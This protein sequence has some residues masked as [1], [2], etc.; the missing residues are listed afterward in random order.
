[1]H[2][3][4]IELEGEDVV[5]RTPSGEWELTLRLLQITGH[6]LDWVEL[7]RLARPFAEKIAAATRETVNI[8]ALAGTQAVCVD[9]VRGNER[10]QLDFNIGS[11]GPL[12]CGGAGKAILAYLPQAK[13]ELAMSPPLAQFMP[14]TLTRP[15]RTRTRA[16][17][18]PWIL[19][20]RSGSCNGNLL[21]R[22]SRARP[23]RSPGGGH[24]HH[25]PHAQGARPGNRTLGGDAA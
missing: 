2:R 5:G 8:N 18:G 23:G 11:R 24:K 10:M 19:D 16:G 13:R 3:M 6:Q 7:P 22:G 4:L 21:R 1:M 9:K 15:C 12:H 17:T 25:R 14:R 20:R